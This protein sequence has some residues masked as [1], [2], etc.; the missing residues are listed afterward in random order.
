L[1]YE[2]S[3]RSANEAA[4]FL[5][6]VQ[7]II[8]RG[9]EEHRMSSLAERIEAKR[10]TETRDIERKLR[11]KFPRTD[12]YRYN[13]V[14][15]RIRIIDERFSGKDLV[16][17]EA[18]VDPLLAKFSEETQSDITLLILLA[19]EECQTSMINMEFEHPSE[20]RL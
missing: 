8:E 2:S 10:T 9:Q 4:A 3:R 5:A 17:R 7:C 13:S 1:R 6:A 14:S 18:M 11:K 16:Q 12:A 20:S 19:P 15:I